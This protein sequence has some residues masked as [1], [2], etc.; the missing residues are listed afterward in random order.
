MRVVF[1]LQ[2]EYRMKRESYNFSIVFEPDST[3][4]I[5]YIR[6]YI[7]P[8]LDTSSIRGVYKHE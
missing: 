5:R 1:L 2:Q 6:M 8:Y 3:Y 7:M 4:Y